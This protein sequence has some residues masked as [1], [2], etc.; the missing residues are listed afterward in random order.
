[1]SKG[2]DNMMERSRKNKKFSFKY[3]IEKWF[4]EDSKNDCKKIAVAAAEMFSLLLMFAMLGIIPAL[5]H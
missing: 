3:R 1:M 5:F 2:V 4:Y